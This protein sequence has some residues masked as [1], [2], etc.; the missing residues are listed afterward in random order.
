MPAPNQVVRRTDYR[1][2]MKPRGRN[3]VEGFLFLIRR[4]PCAE[5]RCM[6]LE[7]LL[8]LLFVGAIITCLLWLLI[9]VGAKLGDLLSKS[10]S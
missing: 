10:K 3:I 4:R 6:I 2:V 5:E 7:N 9:E 8:P 1:F